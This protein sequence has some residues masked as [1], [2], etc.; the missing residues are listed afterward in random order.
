MKR[1]TTG[2]NEFFYLDEDKIKHWGIEDEFLASV[3]K[4]P[5]RDQRIL[6]KVR[7]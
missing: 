2:I 4:S 1:Y 7:C 5:K 6:L 3:I